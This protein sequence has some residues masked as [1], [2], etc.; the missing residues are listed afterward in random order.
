MDIRATVG[1]LVAEKPGLATVFE[2][3]G[4]DYC[5]GGKVTLE[6]AC[7]RQGLD[8]RNVAELLAAS[9]TPADT[10]FPDCASMS[11][12]QL[13]DH[14]LATHHAYLKIELPRLTQLLARTVDAH[15]AK[16]PRLLELQQAY[17]GFCDEIGSHMMK[18]ERI[19]FPVIQNL[20]TAGSSFVSHCGSVANPIRVMEMEHESAGEALELMKKL[21]NGHTAPE[22]ACN[23]WRAL[24][25][26]LAQL[27]R[28]THAH[29]HKENNILFP[30][31]LE[32]EA[33]R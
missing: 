8:P 14:I 24:C 21:T 13:T 27:E 20:E 31:A 25:S 2:K 1:E 4:I 12:V 22:S 26:G 33:K 6:E 9:E 15:G 10:L 7:T 28:D 30:R 19:L 5:C 17:A 16:D 11:L 29:I 3:M 18:E 23:T 32:A